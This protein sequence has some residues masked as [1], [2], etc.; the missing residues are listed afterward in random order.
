[1]K[2]LRYSRSISSSHSRAGMAISLFF[3]EPDAEIGPFSTLLVIGHDPSHPPAAERR[4]RKLEAAPVAGSE[5][6]LAVEQQK[7]AS[8]FL[9]RVVGPGQQGQ[10]FMDIGQSG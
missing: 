1:M 7:I 10:Y 9:D 4:S 2:S 6:G 3:D 5:V 8:K